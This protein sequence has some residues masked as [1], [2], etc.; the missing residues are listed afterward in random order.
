MDL[1]IKG[2]DDAF[3]FTLIGHGFMGQKCGE[4]DEL[5]FSRADV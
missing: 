2:Q 3:A 1:R 5:T 4:E